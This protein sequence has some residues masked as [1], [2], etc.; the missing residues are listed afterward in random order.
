[1]DQ[2]VSMSWTQARPTSAELSEA[3]SVAFERK[4]RSAG[5]AP[6]TARRG[7]RPRLVERWHAF[8]HTG[9]HRHGTAGV[10]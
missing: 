1:M 5:S 6:T 7:R 2:L 9:F 10:H 4:Q 3:A 8:T